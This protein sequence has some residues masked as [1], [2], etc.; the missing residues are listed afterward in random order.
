[1]YL[2]V[3]GS[4]RCPKDGHGFI[5]VVVVHDDIGAANTD[6]GI[7]EM[8]L[9]SGHLPGLDYLAIYQDSKNKPGQQDNYTGEMISKLL[10]STLIDLLEADHDTSV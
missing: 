4:W 7:P 3:G 5:V 2:S 10:S 8:T 1:M 9:G 6:K